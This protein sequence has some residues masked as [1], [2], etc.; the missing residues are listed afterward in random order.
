MKKILIIIGCLILCGCNE[1]IEKMPKDVSITYNVEDV[2]VYDDV[3]VSDIIKKSN[4]EITNLETKINTNKIGKTEVKVY[5][6]YK[7]KK[8]VT[9]YELNVIDNIA[10]R[11]ISGTNRTT[12]INED[13][14]FCQKVFYGDNY[15]KV[16]KCEINGIY[17]ITKKG[18][19]DLEIILTDSSNNITSAPLKLTVIEEY[20]QNKKVKTN[21]DFSEVIKKYKNDNTAIGIDVSRWQSEIDFKKVR[22]AG[23]EFVIMRMAIQSD[24]DKEISLDANFEKNYQDASQNGLKVGVYVYTSVN[25]KKDIAKQVKWLVENL[26]NKELDFPIAFDWENWSN[27]HKYQMSFHDINEIYDVFT[28]NLAK[29]K[30][31]TMLY[32]SKFYLENIW[33]NKEK[34]PVWLAHYTDYTTYQGEY[35][36]WQMTNLGRIDGINGD[37]DINILYKDKYNEIMGDDY[38]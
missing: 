19:Y 8:Y 38:E 23:C 15:D 4:V 13:V 3:Y 12:L 36:L 5:Y 9:H 18:V 20:S 34:N 37:V 14:D 27:W 16:V 24:Y 2:L 29:H 26:K 7:R 35:F 28:Q 25:D 17:D 10:P 21:V 30:Y 32:S 6:N 11:I 31:K 33:V 22:D 1:P